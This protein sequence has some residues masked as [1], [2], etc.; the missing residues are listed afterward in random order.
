MTLST[1]TSLYYYAHLFFLRV[2]KALQY[3]VVGSVITENSSYG[4]LRNL[5]ML[6]SGVLA[7]TGQAL[8]LLL[9]LFFTGFGRSVIS[10]TLGH[11]HMPMC[12]SECVSLTGSPTELRAW[13][14]G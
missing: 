4:H 11:G 1:Y 14:W 6:I 13:V 9:S 3:F 7:S 5:E 2:H 8:I 12:S 10:S